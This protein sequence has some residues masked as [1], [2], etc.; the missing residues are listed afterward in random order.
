M[1]KKERFKRLKE[2]GEAAKQ[3]NQQ[4]RLQ[5]RELKAQVQ[6]LKGRNQLQMQ[7]MKKLEGEL[8]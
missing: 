1:L 8:D 2:G 7:R 6:K 5:V 3:K 4:L